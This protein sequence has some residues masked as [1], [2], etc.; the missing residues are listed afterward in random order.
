MY[1]L[2][3]VSKNEK[4]GP[5]PVTTSPRTTC[6]DACPLKDG[7]CYAEAGGLKIHW[8]AVTNNKRGLPWQE[9]IQAI[10]RLP[11][12]QLWRHNQA[13]D[14]PG[15]RTSIDRQSLKEL[16]EANRGKRGFTYTHYSMDLA[17]NREA[18]KDAN[19]NGFVVNLSA[20]GMHEVDHLVSLGIAP[21]VTLLPKETD[22]SNDPSL[23]KVYFTEARTRVV[24]CPATYRDT[25]CASCQLCAIPVERRNY[26]IGFPAHGFS[27]EKAS[28]IA[29]GRSLPVVSG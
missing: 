14:L 1:H 26:V 10:K 23:P 11:R 12:R 28:K 9:F 8:N 22:R 4:T 13:G 17:E 25:N 21:V 7:P 5:I 19:E 29:R 20:N 18:I 24:V 3:M 2:T 6:P 15:D 27:K 16:V